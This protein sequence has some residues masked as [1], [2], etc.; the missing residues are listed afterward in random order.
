LDGLSGI[1]Q[2]VGREFRDALNATRLGEDIVRAQHNQQDRDG[3]Q[4][5]NR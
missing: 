4:R 5:S 3:G 2:D 1:V